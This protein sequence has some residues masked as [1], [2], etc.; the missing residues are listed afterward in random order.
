MPMSH[1]IFND[2][3][4]ACDLSDTYSLQED[5]RRK[6]GHL[7]LNLLAQENSIRLLRTCEINTKLSFKNDKIIKTFHKF[8]LL[9]LNTRK[10][11]NAE[12]CVESDLDKVSFIPF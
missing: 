8:H 10:N 6:R 7:P 12:K 5:T 4:Y 11:V 1:I 9:S 2:T 3:A